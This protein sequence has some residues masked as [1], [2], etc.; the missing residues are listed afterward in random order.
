MRNVCGGVGSRGFGRG[1]GSLICAWGEDGLRNGA[2]GIASCL[3]GVT[4]DLGLLSG[5]GEDMSNRGYFAFPRTS[6]YASS[7]CAA[8]KEWLRTESFAVNVVPAKAQIFL[9]VADLMLG[10][11]WDVRI[12]PEFGS[13]LAI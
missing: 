13:F 3:E 12:I 5:A 1:D 10:G 8:E 6:R 9:F 2:D 11:C 7:A 4:G